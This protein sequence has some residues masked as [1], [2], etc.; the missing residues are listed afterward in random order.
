[1]SQ[2]VDQLH[3]LIT[4]ERS[5]FLLRDQDGVMDEP[6]GWP[7]LEEIA[8]R[9][10]ASS[11]FEAT[12]NWAVFWSSVPWHDAEV[13]LEL[14]DGPPPQD[15]TRWT[16]SKTTL[17]YSSSGLVYLTELSG[18]EPPPLPLD[19]RRDKG[20]WAVKAS[21]RPGAGWSWTD[22]ELPPRGAEEWKICFWPA[23]GSD[24]GLTH[25]ARRTATSPS[26]RKYLESL[27]RGRDRA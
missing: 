1:M 11:W 13:T 3:G 17:F 21:T 15:D 20:E 24:P 4:V 8:A 18:S 25:A 7:S 22:E 19:L 5:Q 12:L 27:A 10:P 14:W 16:K 2:L 23:H 9:L 26:V 6:P